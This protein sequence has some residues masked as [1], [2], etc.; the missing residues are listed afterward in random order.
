MVGGGV[1]EDMVRL[2]VEACPSGIIMTDADGAIVLVNA[3]IER[4]FGYRR[5]EL[6]G[7]TVDILV[8]S[9]QRGAHRDL[10]SGFAAAPAARRMGA[11]RD[12]YGVRKDGTMIPLEIGL[13]PIETSAGL[14]ILSAITDLRERKL[15]EE[16]FRTVVEASPSGMIVTNAEGRIVLVN[17]EVQ[18][19][20]G[21]QRQDL[22]GQPVE[23]LV[24]TRIRDQHHQFRK[25]FSASPEARTMGAGR[26]LYIVRKDGEELPVEIGLNPIRTPDGPM[27]L[28]AIIDISERKRSEAALRQYAERE[29]LFIAAVKSSA[30]AIITESLDGIVT[31]WNPAAKRCSDFLPRRRS[32][33]ASS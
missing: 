13:N 9:A 27:V 5:D 28:S 25:S 1:S 12:L 32:A 11:G 16:R 17:A 24:P 15:A 22:I 29:Q 3:E 8:P 10:R 14:M 18:R 6:A 20:T 21:Y 31:G 4:L 2:A 33:S 19:L 23:M 30:D 7:Q 26:D